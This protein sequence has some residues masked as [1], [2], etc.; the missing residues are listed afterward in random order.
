MG[1]QLGLFVQGPVQSADSCEY[2]FL[3][4]SIL[5]LIH[6]KEVFPTA[7]NSF[8]YFLL[9]QVELYGPIPVRVQNRTQPQMPIPGKFCLSHSLSDTL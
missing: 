6:V 4:L 5:C 2:G 1:H 7:A 3:P 8:I 9:L